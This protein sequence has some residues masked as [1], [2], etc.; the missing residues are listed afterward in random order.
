MWVSVWFVEQARKQYLFQK[1]TD[2]KSNWG[3]LISHVP[4]R[5]MMKQLSCKT[6]C[7]EYTVEDISHAKK[8]LQHR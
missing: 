2:T 5:M 1:V 4:D 6:G 3:D 8:N 7:C